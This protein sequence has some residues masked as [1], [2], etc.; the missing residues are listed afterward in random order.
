M[1]ASFFMEN[2]RE[3]VLFWKKR[4]EEIAAVGNH[5]SQHF[6]HIGLPYSNQI[7]QKTET[8]LYAKW[9]LSPKNAQITGFTASLYMGN[10]IFTRKHARLSHH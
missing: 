10:V 2:R 8:T 5:V 3:A 4:N 9:D 7:K 1:R 6:N